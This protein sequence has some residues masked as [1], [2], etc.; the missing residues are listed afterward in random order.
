[1]EVVR[2]CGGFVVVCRVLCGVALDVARLPR[3]T[4]RLGGFK[5]PPGVTEKAAKFFASVVRSVVRQA[6]C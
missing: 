1:M 6:G 4:N 3:L 5:S 2:L